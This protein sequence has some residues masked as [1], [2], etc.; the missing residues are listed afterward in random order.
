MPSKRKQR[1][2]DRRSPEDTLIAAALCVEQSPAQFVIEIVHADNAEDA[3]VTELAD[4][5]LR[6]M[7]SEGIASARIN[8]HAQTATQTIWQSANWLDRIEETSPPPEPQA[9]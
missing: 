9:A 5:C 8:S 7:Q 4:R 2:K 3:L 6:K 1:K